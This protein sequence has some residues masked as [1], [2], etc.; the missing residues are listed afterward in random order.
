M[1]AVSV[2]QTFIIQMSSTILFFF[3][4]FL[5]KYHSALPP[6]YFFGYFL[7]NAIG[8]LFCFFFLPFA[9]CPRRGSVTTQHNF[10]HSR[11]LRSMTTFLCCCCL[12]FQE[13]ISVFILLQFL[14]TEMM[15][16]RNIVRLFLLMGVLAC[17]RPSWPA[18]GVST[19][20]VS[21]NKFM[22]SSTVSTLCL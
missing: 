7:K 2:G 5:F 13:S 4:F 10:T 11:Y 1:F 18:A 22:I 17:L 21:Y 14:N 12:F 6:S 16:D 20:M 15:M 8:P 9:K 3:F 19:Y